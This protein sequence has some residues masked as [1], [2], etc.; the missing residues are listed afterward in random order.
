[1]EGMQLDVALDR[2]S[3]RRTARDLLASLPADLSQHTVRVDFAGHVSA[4]PSF[5]DELVR[6]VLV[7]RQAARLDFVDVPARLS[8]RLE[9]SARRREVSDRISIDRRG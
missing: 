5:L 2:T 9:D 1:V 7:E 6:V 3:S 8:V 4:P